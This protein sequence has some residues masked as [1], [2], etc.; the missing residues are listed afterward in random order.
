MKKLIHII[1]LASAFGVLN[2]LNAQSIESILESHFKI[3]GQEKLLNIQTIVTKGILRQSGLEIELSTFIQRPNKYR[4]EG[5]YEGFTFVE[6]FD[7][8]IGWTFNQMLGE[9]EP[10]LIKDEEL[11]LLKTQANIDGLLFNYRTKGFEIRILEP[12]SIGNVLTD[13]ILLSKPSGLKVSY[14]LDSETSVIV[15]STTVATIGGIERNYE[16]IYTEYRYVNNILFPFSVDVYID[17]DLIMEVQYTSIELNTEIDEYRF[18]TP[19]SLKNKI[20]S[21]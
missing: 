12:E 17:G 7:G 16:S 10:S 8:K 14:N 13:V 4:L 11:E 15:K 21:N 9:T 5:R 6:V 3:V 19:Q 2:I 20:E 1:F 18:A